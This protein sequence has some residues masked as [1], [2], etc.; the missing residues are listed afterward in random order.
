MASLSID[1]QEDT[2]FPF[3]MRDLPP[4]SHLGEQ[5]QTPVHQ[6]PVS[7]EAEG[8]APNGRPPSLPGTPPLPRSIPCHPAGSPMVPNRPNRVRQDAEF[9]PV[10]LRR[11]FASQ[12]SVDCPLSPASRPRSPWGRFDPYDDSPEDQ[13]KE[14]VGFATLPNQVHRK[15]VKK[16]F[17]FTLM[18]AGESGLGKSTLINS[19]FLTDLYKDRKVPTAQERIDQTI[20]IVKH[21][22]SIEEKGIKLRLTI[23]DTPG[24]G[25]AIDNTESSGEFSARDVVLLTDFVCVSWKPIEDY[26]DQQFEQYFRDES[27]LNRRNIQD[28]RVHCCLYFISPFGHG[29][30]GYCSSLILR[31]L[32]VAC[33][34]ALHEKVN[35]VPILAKADSLTQEEVFRK[36]IKIREEIKQFGINIYQFPECDSDE[37]EDFKTQDQ[38]LKDSIPFAVIGSNIQ[39][40][41]NGRKFR[42]RVYP[43]GVVE[44]EDPAHSDFL[45]LRNMLVRTHMEDLK[46]LTQEMHYENYRA[47]CIQNMTRM[48]VQERKRSLREKHQD[49]SEADFPL[50]L[51]A[52][53]TETERLIFEKDEELKKMQ[54]VLE[55]IQE[56]M[57]NS[58]RGGC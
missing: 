6:T 16:G 46:E 48:V 44:V 41:S 2:Q 56:Q 20:N 55:R 7:R 19:L 45:L 14:Y 5:H 23:I 42:G 18:V 29:Y 36:K 35:I 15:T 27:G 54:E 21:T 57:Q 37:D 52:V 13:D 38:I 33:M 58:Q 50:P 30:A 10:P 53:D 24:F 3:A 12:V 26:I 17:T 9:H 31:P 51:V 22:L 39:M 34:K 49:L 8:A 32:D 11:Q 40:E 25:D 4:V 43:W 47:Q 28:N 1:D